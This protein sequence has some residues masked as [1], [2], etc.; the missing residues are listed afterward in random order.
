MKNLM[1][2]MML[3]GL[4][5]LML[6]SCLNND[7]SYN[8]GFPVLQAGHAYVYA[9][10][11]NDSLYVFSYGSWT[12]TNGAMNTGWCLAKSPRCLLSFAPSDAIFQ[13]SA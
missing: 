10:N 9:N 12:I 1:R 2:T 8:A 11:L 5:G 6:T 3:G 4:V 13:C 7:E